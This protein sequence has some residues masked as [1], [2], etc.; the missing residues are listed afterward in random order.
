MYWEETN[1]QNYSL[2]E[3]FMDASLVQLFLSM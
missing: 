2:G 3:E 1:S